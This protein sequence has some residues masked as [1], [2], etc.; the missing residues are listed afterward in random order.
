MYKRKPAYII[1][2][3]VY[4]YIIL[5]KAKLAS[6]F[7]L[8]E[9]YTLDEALKLYALY[10]MDMDIQNGKAEEMRERRE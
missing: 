6:M 8:K 5:I 3:L 10:R 1:I 4:T 7:E 2:I 9:Y